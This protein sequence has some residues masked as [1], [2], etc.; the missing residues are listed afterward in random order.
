MRWRETAAITAST[1]LA[2]LDLTRFW[3]LALGLSVVAAG[4]FVLTHSDGLAEL[5]DAVLPRRFPGRRWIIWLATTGAA[6]AAM[7]AGAALIVWA[8]L[9]R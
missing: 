8:L 9:L 1:P 2:A 3:V 5:N 7:A 6:G 4:G